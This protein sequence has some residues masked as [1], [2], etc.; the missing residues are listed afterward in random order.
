M[1]GKNSGGWV[2]TEGPYP[3]NLC[4]RQTARDYYSSMRQGADRVPLYS[5][6]HVNLV[7]LLCGP[8]STETGS[9]QLEVHPCGPLLFLLVRRGGLFPFSMVVISYLTYFWR[10]L[11]TCS[12]VCTV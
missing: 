9:S 10:L 12:Q 6:P 3:T 5:L 7:G 2:V 4:A 1:G 11:F 8:G